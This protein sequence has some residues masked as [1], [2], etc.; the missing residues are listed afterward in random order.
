MNRDEGLYIATN[1][2]TINT[3]WEYLRANKLIPYHGSNICGSCQ[4]FD[5]THC[6]LPYFIEADHKIVVK[7]LDVYGKKKQIFSGYVLRFKLK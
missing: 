7:M 6:Q 5:F 2:Y 4:L 1:T 3:P